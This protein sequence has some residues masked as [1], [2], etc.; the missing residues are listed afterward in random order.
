MKGRQTAK[1]VSASAQAR[2][3]SPLEKQSTVETCSTV[4]DAWTTRVVQGR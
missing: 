1:P 3:C 2:E 4:V